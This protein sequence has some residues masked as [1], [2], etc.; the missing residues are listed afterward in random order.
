MDNA[1]ADAQLGDSPADGSH[2]PPAAAPCP[3]EPARAAAN[4]SAELP[5]ELAPFDGWNESPTRED[6]EQTS[7]ALAS[8]FFPDP[9]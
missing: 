6:I 9:T 2:A 1:P 3:R 7:R 8:L 5:A 4:G